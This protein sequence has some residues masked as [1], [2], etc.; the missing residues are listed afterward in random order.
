[1]DGSIFG[2]RPR[3]V[4]ELV[5]ERGRRVKNEPEFNRVLGP[6]Q[7]AILTSILEDVV[8]RGTGRRAAIAGHEVAGKTGTTENYGDAWFVGYNEHAGAGRRRLGGLP[9]HAAA[10]ADRVRRRRG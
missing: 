3:V 8:R 5:D 7:N 6:A 1:M 4:R 10:D 9:D 2:N